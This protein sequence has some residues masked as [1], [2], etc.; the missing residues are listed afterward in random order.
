ME[1]EIYCDVFPVNT[2]NNLW[3]ADIVSQYI[4][5]SP[6]GIAITTLPIL[7]HINQ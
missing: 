3:V 6:R 2:S 1:Y 4:G 5:Y 7:Y